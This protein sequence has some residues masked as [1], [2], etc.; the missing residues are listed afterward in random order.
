MANRPQDRL[1]NQWLAIPPC[2]FRVRS[3]LLMM[4]FYTALVPTPE[5]VIGKLYFGPRYVSAHTRYRTN[6][7]PGSILIKQ[8]IHDSQYDHLRYI[9]YSIHAGSCR[10]C[11][12]IIAMA[13]SGLRCLWKE[14][15][16]RKIRTRT[17]ATV[18]RYFWIASV[19]ASSEENV[20]IGRPR[21]SQEAITTNPPNYSASEKRCRKSALSFFLDPAACFLSP[22]G[23]PGDL[24]TYTV[25]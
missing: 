15:R 14:K 1:A 25:S 16:T 24:K 10:F 23:L 11:A 18:A 12:F 8:T 17:R 4:C 3:A 20:P 19:N 9:V 6:Q 13:P 7:A 2:D 22:N 5:L 21:N